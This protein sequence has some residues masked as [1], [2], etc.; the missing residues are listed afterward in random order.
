M[1]KKTL[2]NAREKVKILSFAETAF[3]SE[4]QKE[5]TISPLN[6]TLSKKKKK[7]GQAFIS[8]SLLRRLHRRKRP[9]VVLC[10]ASPPVHISS[11]YVCGSVR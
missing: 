11:R 10:I 8:D 9:F 7:E 5:E 4:K 6:E 2:Y 3:S 1:Q